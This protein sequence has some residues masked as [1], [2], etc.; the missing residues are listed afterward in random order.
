M[1]KGAHDHLPLPPGTID[2]L[3]PIVTFN[4]RMSRAVNMMEFVLI[5]T[6]AGMHIGY[7]MMAAY[8]VSKLGVKAGRPGLPSTGKSSFAVMVALGMPI[9]AALLVTAIAPIVDPVSTTL[10]VTGDMA[11]TTI[12]G[13]LGLAWEG[14]RDPSVPVSGAQ[15]V[16]A[17]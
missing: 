1:M 13:R 4:V 11:I 17:S 16:A 3:L 7:G 5:G 8:L 15:P 2:F 14:T 10:N 12:A 9:E 6:L